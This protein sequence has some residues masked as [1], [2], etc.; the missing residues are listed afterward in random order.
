MSSIFYLSVVLYIVYPKHPVWLDSSSIYNAALRFS[1]HYTGASTSAEPQQ[2]SLFTTVITLSYT[3]GAKEAE[4]I[5]LRDTVRELQNKNIALIKIHFCSE[6]E[7]TKCSK[8]NIKVLHTK[9]VSS[10]TRLRRKL[11]PNPFQHYYTKI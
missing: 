3:T 6:N 8:K 1:V 4:I 7:N 9:A 5:L 2:S 10:N 11:S